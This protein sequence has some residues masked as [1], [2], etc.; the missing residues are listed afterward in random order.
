[1]MDPQYSLALLWLSRWPGPAVSRP[2]AERNMKR[3]KDYDRSLLTYYARR[4]TPAL[5]AFHATAYLK[6]SF[7]PNIAYAT[8]WC[9]IHSYV[10]VGKRPRR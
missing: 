4:L 8:V 7:S 10:E 3:L 2:D 9:L 6:V 1:M 5:A